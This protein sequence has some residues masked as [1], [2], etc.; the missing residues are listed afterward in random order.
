MY[1]HCVYVSFSSFVRVR[2]QI[3]EA[4]FGYILCGAHI[5]GSKWQSL[6]SKIDHD[7]IT[8]FLRTT[9]PNHPEFETKRLPILKRAWSII[10]LWMTNSFGR[11]K[12]FSCWAIMY[13]FTPCK[14]MAIILSEFQESYKFHPMVIN[15]PEINHR[16]AKATII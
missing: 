8:F 7:T 5:V 11:W 15:Y 3:N 14:L 2:T 6:A 9:M 1:Q 12:E 4:S 13:I 16:S 10:N